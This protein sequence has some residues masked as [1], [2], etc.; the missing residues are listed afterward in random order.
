MKRLLICVCILSLLSG[1]NVRDVEK[2]AFVVTLGVDKVDEP[3]KVEVSFKIALPT[4]DPKAGLGEFTV[5]SVKA[6]SLAEAVRRAKSKMDKELDFGHTKVIILGKGLLNEDVKPVLY[7]AQ[8]RRDIQMIS[9][10]A[11]GDPSAKKVLAVKP[12][13]ERV[14]AGYLINMLG[15]EGSESP[16][17]VR[18]FL[19]D[20]QRKISEYGW[21][22][23]LPVVKAAGSD[24]LII[25]RAVLLN[26]EKVRVGLTPDETRLYN[27][28]V[29]ED[30]T[31]SFT[32][33]T[34]GKTKYSINAESTKAKYKIHG[35][36]W[37]KIKFNIK[38]NGVLE[39]DRQEGYFTEKKQKEASS[40]IETDFNVRVL[41]LLEKIRKHKV[42]PIGFGFRYQA[43]HWKRDEQEEWARIY[44]KAKFEVHTE[45]EIKSTGIL[46]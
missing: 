31:S 13:S 28:L 37:P 2:R 11:V 10:I 39:E 23:V 33:T 46:R 40:I 1:C 20:M 18:E 30:T 45:V 32:A 35:G 26:D 17:L 29:N 38:I 12:M 15:R 8:R 43:E 36:S 16:F 21:D 14:P 6:G 9:Y 4:G 5:L 25:D 42:D 19:F 22:P 24:S 41:D 44:D 27:L 34:N 7:W 3:N